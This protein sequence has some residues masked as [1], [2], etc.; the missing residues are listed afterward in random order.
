MLLSDDFDGKQFKKLL[1]FFANFLLVCLGVK[2]ILLWVALAGTHL[3]QP[4]PSES[5]PLPIP[6]RSTRYMTLLDLKYL[7]SSKV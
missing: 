7:S 1:A 5:G 6:R 3:L 2:R 4:N